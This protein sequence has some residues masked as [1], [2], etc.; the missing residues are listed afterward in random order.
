MDAKRAGESE[1][2]ELKDRFLHMTAHALRS[3]L[4]AILAYSGMLLK[5]KG[6]GADREKAARIIDKEVKVLMALVDDIQDTLRLRSTPSAWKSAEM[7]AA[8]AGKRAVESLAD[9]YEKASV[10]LEF[11]SAPGLPRVKADEAAVLRALQGLLRH[12]LRRLG[13]SGGKASVRVEADPV[14]ARLV[15]EAAARGQTDEIT[16]S[17]ELEPR[18]AYAAAVAHAAGS[19]LAAETKGP[20]GRITFALR[21]KPP[22]IL[23]CD[24]DES[25]RGLVADHCSSLG[26]EVT[27]LAG[28]YQAL[29]WLK[30]QPD[31][32]RLELAI[33]DMVMPGGGAPPIISALREARATTGV[34][35]LIMTAAHENLPAIPPPSGL[36]KKPFTV[37]DVDA[38][39]RAIMKGR[40]GW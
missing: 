36:L 16:G 4:T 2:D 21:G 23:V 40:P 5:E 29:D 38:A 24:D 35:I 12:V 10:G 31:G 25:I 1:L 9:E 11:E 26:R 30:A 34:P 32:E 18:L 7:D 15:V 33:V 6:D 3:P 27:S 8:A 28:T 17:L 20:L 19:R 39:V 37:D 14:G 22:R 13:P